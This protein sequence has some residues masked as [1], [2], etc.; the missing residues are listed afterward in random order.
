MSITPRVLTLL[1]FS[2]Q[3]IAVA[4]IVFHP[5]S[6]SAPDGRLRIDFLDVGQGDSALVTMPDNTTVLIDG[7]GRPGPFDKAFD[8]DGDSTFERDTRSI[9]EAVVSEH[10]WWR[11]LDHIDYVIATHADADHIDGLND[12]ARNFNVRAAVVARTPSRDAEYLKFVDTLAAGNIPVHTIGAGDV[13]RFGGV[14]ASV[15]WPLSSG[16][17]DAPSANNDS[18]VLRL[19]FGERSILL[20]AD[21]ETPAEN[22]LLKLNAAHENSSERFIRRF[23]SLRADVVKVAHH[24]SKTSSTENFVAATRARVAVIPVGQTSMFGHPHVEVVKRWEASAAQ[25]LTTGGQ[26]T[27]TVIT[28]GRDLTVQTF[29]EKR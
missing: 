20:T 21:I 26:G 29:A 19:Q 28:D 6:E 7:G 25:V 9:G 11:G 5:L 3:L 8:G 16:N 27:I 1:A 2:T 22:A 23:D 24:G 13:L 14:A 18:V 15:L 17:T 10:L 4:L 12:V